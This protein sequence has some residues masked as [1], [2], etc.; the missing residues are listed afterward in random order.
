MFYD[1]SVDTMDGHR[2]AFHQLKALMKYKANQ[3]YD[4]EFN[5]KKGISVEFE[6][7]EGIFNGIVI[8]SKSNTV[9]AVFL[10]PPTSW[11]VQKNL[12]T[13]SNW[14][15]FILCRKILMETKN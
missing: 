1:T 12:E 15:V 4:F 8:T 5:W 9:K 13:S 14:L 7:D 10:L 2:V 6:T 11:R 3:F